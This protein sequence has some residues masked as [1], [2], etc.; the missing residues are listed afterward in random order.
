MRP[1]TNI[2]SESEIR[3][4]LAAAGFPPAAVDDG[5]EVIRCETVPSFNASSLSPN[6]LYAGLFQHW[7]EAWDERSAK[8]GVAGMSPYDPAAN[9]AV[10]FY[11]WSPKQ[12]FSGHW[13]HCGKD[14]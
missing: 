10:G 2:L 13:P 9:I 6:G 8:A 1:P 3:A 5:V 12:T 14:R 11:L 7:L 4:L